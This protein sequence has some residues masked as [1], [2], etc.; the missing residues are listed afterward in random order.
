MELDPGPFGSQALPP[1]DAAGL[2][3]GW[4]ISW[5]SYSWLCGLGSPWSWVLGCLGKGFV[6]PEAV[7]DLLVSKARSQ[8]DWLWVLED[9]VLVSVQW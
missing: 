9:P 1:E 2:L 5:H 3:E 6:R 4:I 7:A 8:D